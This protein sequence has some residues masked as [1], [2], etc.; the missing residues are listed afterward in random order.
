MATEQILSQAQDTTP[1]NAALD[2]RHVGAVAAQLEATGTDRARLAR[3]INVL[4]TSDID[5]TSEGPLIARLFRVP[6][7]DTPVA[8][9]P[10]WRESMRLYCGD[11]EVTPIHPF[12]IEQRTADHNV[13]YEGLYVFDRGSVGPL[14]G[15]VK[16]VLVSDTAPDKPDTRTIDAKILQQVQQDFAPYRPRR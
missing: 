15:T 12:R 1:A 6:D 8:A 5:E 13:I 7:L 3:A 11:A 14:C 16:L 9:A 10:G 2:L 4:L